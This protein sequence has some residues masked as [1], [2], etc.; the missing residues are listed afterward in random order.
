MVFPL[1][2]S[3]CFAYGMVGA[4]VVRG[5]LWFSLALARS[6]QLLLLRRLM[7]KPPLCWAFAWEA[8]GCTAETLSLSFKIERYRNSHK[9]GKKIASGCLVFI[10]IPYL[11][12]SFRLDQ[13]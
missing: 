8:L 6:D 5:K 4:E 13:K 9:A 1:W 12:C 3:S 7:L 2:G 10:K 11:A